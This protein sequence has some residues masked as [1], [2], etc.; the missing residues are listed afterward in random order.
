[1]K[2]EIS[3]LKNGEARRE[4]ER[5]GGVGERRAENCGEC[6][7]I[8]DRPAQPKSVCGG[9]REE[10]GRLK[11]GSGGIRGARARLKDGVEEA[12]AQDLGLDF[13]L[14][15]DWEGNGKEGEVRDRAGLAKAASGGAEVSQNLFS[16]LDSK[17]TSN[18]RSNANALLELNSNANSNASAGADRTAGITEMAGRE[19]GKLLDADGGTGRRQDARGCVPSNTNAD[20][21]T[22]LSSIVDEFSRTNGMGQAE[23]ARR[24]SG[25]GSADSRM[26]GERFFAERT[27]ARNSAYAAAYRDK[28]EQVAR[29]LR[30]GEG[31]S[32]FGPVR[33]KPEVLERNRQ[34]DAKRAGSRSP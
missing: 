5:A 29:D 26:G 25:A 13:G 23:R 33:V 10:N 32:S 12:H 11:S 3:D 7:G 18:A 27:A 14:G 9:I 31:P 8:G 21:L 24:D 19:C 34:R 15:W 17:A 22:K 20:S 2:F 4:D 16:D 6:G 28:A 1:M 30:V